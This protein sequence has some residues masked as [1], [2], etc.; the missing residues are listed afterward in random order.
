[1]SVEMEPL[2]PALSHHPMNG[3]GEERRLQV[4]GTTELLTVE[5]GRAAAARFKVTPHPLLPD[6]PGPDRLANLLRDRRN[7]EPLAEAYA[8]REEAIANAKADPFN[9]DLEPPHWKE[10][11]RL[12]AEVEREKEKGKSEMVLFLALLGGNRSAKSFFAGSRLMRSAV[13]HPHATVLCLSENFEASVI[14]VQKILWHY[15]PREFKELNGKQSKK[16]YI[17]YSTHH[18]FSD[19]M[20]VLP[21]GTKFLFKTYQQDPGDM[22]GVMFGVPGKI[23]PAV[24]ADE[25]LRVNWWLMLQ[26]RLRFQ[27]A[28][29]IWSFTPIHG[30][31]AT[32]KEFVGDAAETLESRVAELL[33]E[34]VNV[35][36]LPVGHMPYIQRPAV[37]RG[38]VIYFWSEFNRYGDGQRSFYDAVKDDCRGRSSEYTQRI[39][40]GYTRDTIG[41][42]FP[43]WGA[44]N[45]VKPEH[46]PKVGTDY[47]FADPAGGRNWASM[48]VRVTPEDRFY[49]MADWPDRQ[50]YGEWAVPNTEAAG[51]NLAKLHKTGAAQNS[52]GL[53][54][55]QLRVVWRAIEAQLGLA[56]FT[57]YIDSRAAHNPHAGEHGGTCLIEQLRVEGV[58]VEGVGADEG[59]VFVPAS[60]TDVETRITEVN[61]LL[62]WD[63]TRPLDMVV[64]APRLFVSAAAEQV[65][66]T[67]NQW[68]GPSGGDKHPLKDFADLLGYMAMANLAHYD[69]KEE[70]CYQ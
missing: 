2:T 36:G 5:Q 10:A 59:M 63:E 11:D 40:Y 33:P 55:P 4:A 43:K 34:R 1:M 64:N 25:N 42:P 28:Q 18:G 52:L 54:T 32:I 45:V 65:I 9:H 8:R 38:R 50:T 47:F 62:H 35:P 68:P 66:Q 53:G 69:E 6:F 70:A 48:W 15:L 51:D 20:L 41:K 31:T 14:T 37:S 26:R 29:C 46:L 27:Q 16:F 24:W 57:R 19:Q 30:M 67:F 61:R 58:G 3:K 44:W 22:E 13:Q 17:K 39:A 49:I 7:W 12:L 56:P 21:N 23:I 60:G